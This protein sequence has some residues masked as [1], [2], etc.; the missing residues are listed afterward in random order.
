MTKRAIFQLYHSENKSSLE[1]I[2]MMSV[3]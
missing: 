1:E 2:M 3:L